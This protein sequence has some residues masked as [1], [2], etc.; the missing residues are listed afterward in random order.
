[1]DKS[2]DKTRASTSSL[3]SDQRQLRNST[4]EED[5][6]LESEEKENLEMENIIL[7]VWFLENLKPKPHW[8]QKHCGRVDST[9]DTCD[10][11][12]QWTTA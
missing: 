10:D 1:M 2:M 11:H 7:N 6:V 3:S 9:E 8:L 5:E 12:L 4:G